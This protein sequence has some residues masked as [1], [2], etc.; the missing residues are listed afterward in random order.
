MTGPQADPAA[1]SRT[2]PPR[3]GAPRTPLVP[4]NG[5]PRGRPGWADYLRDPRS[6][7]LSFLAAALVIGGGRKAY[8]ALQARRISAAI[9]GSNPHVED[10]EAAADHG[11]LVLIDLFRLLETADRPE[12]R[13]A[14]GRSLARLWKLDALIPEEEKAIVR[15]G[16]TVTW[17]ARRK[18]PRNLVAPI[19]IRVDFA[20]PFLAPGARGVGPEHL[21]WSYRLTGTERARLEAWT[22]A[23]PGVPSATFTI[24]PEDFATLGPHRLALQARTRTVGLT[25]TWELD[26]PHI[27][28]SFEFDPHLTVD[29]LLTL[30]DEGRA[31]R[32]AQAVRLEAPTDPVPPLDLTPDLVLRDPPVIRLRTPLPCDL[33]HRVA[34]EVEGIPGSFAAGTVVAVAADLPPDLPLDLP[35]GPI[36]GIPA[37]TLDR[38]GPRQIRAVLTADASLG[39]TNPAIRSVWPASITTDWVEVRVIRR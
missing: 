34:I 3:T 21:V 33:A 2:N 36:E 37:A 12:V 31:G 16:F 27:P 7:V 19:P 23:A 8:Q 1:S 9:A 28:F 30:P 14:A 13:A 32:F 24:Y 39:W 6:A 22:E 4:P 18:Y 17:H 26:L 15:R 11:R 20:V 10:V 35:I 25:D 5:V 29:A 38:P